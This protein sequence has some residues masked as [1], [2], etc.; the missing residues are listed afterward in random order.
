[1]FDGWGYVN[2]FERE[3]GKVRRIDSYAIPEALDPAFAFGFGDLSV[4]E[5]AM[6]PGENLAYSSYYAGGMRVFEFG[7]GGIEEVGHFIDAGGNNFWG[8]E[9]FV[10]KPRLPG[11]W[12]EAP[13]RGLRPRLR[14]LRSSATTRTSTRVRPRQR[15]DK[16]RGAASGYPSRVH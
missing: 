16:R 7:A 12:K 11:T 15:C 6:D 1:M 3:N 2:L 13:V 5:F 9:T 10:L 4:H 8:V 14:H